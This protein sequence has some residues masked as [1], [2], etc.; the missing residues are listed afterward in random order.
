M[1]S[2]L[3]EEES[4]A[5]AKAGEA[6]GALKKMS[7]MDESLA[8][9]FE[10]L[11]SALIQIDETVSEVRRYASSLLADPGRLEEVNDRLDLIRSLKKK[12][13]EN[14]EDILAFGEKAKDELAT[15]EQDQEDAGQLA[16]EVEKLGAKN[17]FFGP[18]PRRDK[19]YTC[20]LDLKNR[21]KKE[22]AE[23]CH[24]E[25]TDSAPVYIRRRPEK[26]PA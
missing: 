21:Y 25:N 23:P 8:P 6:T 13:G 11:S 12:Y 16:E 4:S 18:C 1:V 2:A 14:I 22:L 3:D 26:P 5:V 15:I 17:G 20:R 9:P 19:A 24:A 7:E 10:S